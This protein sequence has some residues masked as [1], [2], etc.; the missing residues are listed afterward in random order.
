MAQSHE[1]WQQPGSS[2]VGAGQAD[3]HEQ[4]RDLRRLGGDAKIAR[5]CDHGPGARGRPIERR[6]DGAAAAPDREDQIAGEPRE[7]EQPGRV[8]LEEVSDDVL[9]VPARAEAAPR[10]G[11]QHGPDAGLGVERAEGVA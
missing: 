6:D 9:D 8:P 4:K 2:H 3:P 10:A 5:R 11:E 1:P 7:R